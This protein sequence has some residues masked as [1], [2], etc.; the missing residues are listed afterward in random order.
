MM[1]ESQAFLP[2]LAA[3]PDTGIGWAMV[4]V[5]ALLGRWGWIVSAVSLALIVHLRH[6]RSAIFAMFVAVALPGSLLLLAI[7]A[8]FYSLPLIRPASPSREVEVR[9]ASP[10]TP[11]DDAK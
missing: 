2:L 6:S 9:S 4:A 11:S 1:R 10:A 3:E 7:S 8:V 5:F